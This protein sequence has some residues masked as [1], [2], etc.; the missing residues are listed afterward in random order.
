MSL[1]SDREGKEIKSTDY[2]SSNAWSGIIAVFEKHK[3]EDALSHDYPSECPDGRG[4]CGFDE[5]LFR[6]SLRAIIPDMEY[7][8]PSI[9]NELP[10]EDKDEAKLRS[11]IEQYAILDTIEFIYSQLAFFGEEEGAV[12]GADLASPF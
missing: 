2:V 1:Y 10:F 7:P 9:G 12:G 6:N 4:I 8:F 3:R 11:Q 5:T